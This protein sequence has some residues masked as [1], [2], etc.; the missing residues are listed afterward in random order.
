MSKAYILGA[1]HCSDTQNFVSDPRF[2]KATRNMMMAFGAAQKAIAGFEGALTDCG[3]ILGSSH[4]ELEVTLQFLKTFAESATARPLLFQ[5]SLHNSTAGFVSLSWRFTGPMLT[6]SNCYFS[7]EDAID[8]GILMLNENQCRFCLVVGVE[9][10]VPELIPGL[11]DAGLQNENWGEGAGAVL[12]ASPQGVKDLKAK[13]LGE[14]DS[15]SCS[16]RRGEILEMPTGFYES[17]AVE[18]LARAALSEPTP[19]VLK[20]DKPDGTFS[21]ISWRR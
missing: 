6:V 12:L 14:I 2:R 8:A 5:N 19:A 17:N 18:I 7:G 21:R 10:K 3:F 1:G 15:V 13:P 20:L 9:A 11:L 4:G 16:H